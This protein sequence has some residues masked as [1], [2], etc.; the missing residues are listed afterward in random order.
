[1]NLFNK[2]LALAIALPFTFFICD[3]LNAQSY[4]IQ[5]SQEYYYFADSTNDQI[6]E[7]SADSANYANSDSVFHLFPLLETDNAECFKDD[8]N[9]WMGK[10]HLEEADGTSKGCGGSENCRMVCL[11]T[12]MLC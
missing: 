8:G 1:M 12:G 2:I 10:L 6:I 3:T 7:F 4:R 9:H 5:S 11:T